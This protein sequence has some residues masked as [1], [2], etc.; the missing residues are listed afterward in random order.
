MRRFA[1][2][3]LLLAA[4]AAHAQPRD[5][6]ITR[7]VAYGN[8]PLQRFNV[9]APRNA[10]NAPVIFMVHG[11]GWR[12][13][14]KAMRGAIDNKV[15]HWVPRGFIVISA[16]YR[17]LPTSVSEQ[18]NDVARAIATAQQRIGEWGGDPHAFIL[19]GHSAGAHLVAL[20][21]SSRALV[22]RN[23]VQ[24]WRAAV[25][26][27]SAALDVPGL[28][29]QRHLPLYDAAFGSDAA[30]WRALSPQDVLDGARP[31]MMLICSS[32]RRESTDHAHAFAAKATRLGT[33]VVVREEERSHREINVD[34]GL[35]NGYTE[36][37]DEFIETAGGPPAAGPRARTR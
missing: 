7:D 36:A 30:T 17:L 14:D 5:M 21:A 32:R 1:V 23:H 2:V 13:G 29:Q 25:I 11:G 4:V 34:L 6:R 20:V 28:M 19:M 22:S 24:S 8:D 10:H 35:E 16:N 18:A 3:L 26:L 12:D 31:P 9:Y 33:R 15:A 37:V 27:D